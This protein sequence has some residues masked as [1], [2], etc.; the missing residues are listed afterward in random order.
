MVNLTMAALAMAVVAGR[1]WTIVVVQDGHVT[2]REIQSQGGEWTQQ[3]RAWSGPLQW[4][5][6]SSA[7]A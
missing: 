6:P 2:S 4:R 3:A 5:M 7:T 1:S